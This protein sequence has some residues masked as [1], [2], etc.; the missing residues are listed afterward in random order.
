MIYINKL[1]KWFNKKYFI[2]IFYSSNLVRNNSLISINNL[3]AI[4]QMKYQGLILSNEIN[5][6]EFF[7]NSKML[8]LVEYNKYLYNI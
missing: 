5:K 6:Y 7:V 8:N 1:K 4:I 3:K 2:L